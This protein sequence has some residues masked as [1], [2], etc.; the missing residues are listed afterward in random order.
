ME[1]MMTPSGNPSLIPSASDAGNLPLPSTTPQDLPVTESP[2]QM[3]LPPSSVPTT[4]GELSVPPQ[5]STELPSTVLPSTGTLEEPQ[6]LAQLP[7]TPMLEE[8]PIPLEPASTV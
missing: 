3:P 1:S 8:E 5:S 2:T 6:P 7:P 4:S